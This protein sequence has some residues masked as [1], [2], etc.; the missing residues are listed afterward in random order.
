M[1]QDVHMVSNDLTYGHCDPGGE[2]C[3]LPEPVS[4]P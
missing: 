3:N 1:M 2:P 4:L